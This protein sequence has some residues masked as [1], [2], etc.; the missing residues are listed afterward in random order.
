MKQ[1]IIAGI[2][3]FGLNSAIVVAETPSF[4]KFEVGY[5]VTKNG[6]S[7]V[8]DYDGLTLRGSYEFMDNLYVTGSYSDETQ[9][10]KSELTDDKFEINSYSLG[11]G[12]YLP[13]GESNA[14]YM[15]ASYADIEVEVDGVSQ[16]EDGY[17]ATTGI[18]S[19]VTDQLE[20]YGELSHLAFDTQATTLSAG[21]RYHFTDNLGIFAE[22]SRAD[23]DTN[24]Y[25]IG[26]NIKF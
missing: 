4:N 7:D 15:E 24:Q 16:S 12:F 13:L 17:I 2:A 20:I 5:G 25:M 6:E 3:I 23:F 10:E 9:S 8:F 1:F 21:T 11:A 26:A 22:V 14:F 19:M 18:R